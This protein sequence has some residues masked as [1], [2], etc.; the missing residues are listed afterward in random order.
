MKLREEDRE[1][2]IKFEQVWKVRNSHMVP[3]FPTQY[4]FCC[5]KE[6]CSHPVGFRYSILVSRWA[7]FV[8]VANPLVMNFVLDITKKRAL[9]MFVK[10]N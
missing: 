6:G 2:L 1:S 3:N 9:L 7:F 4:M 10:V 8:L 5:F